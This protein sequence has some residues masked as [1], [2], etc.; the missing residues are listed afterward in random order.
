[1][2]DIL[3]RKICKEKSKAKRSKMLLNMIVSMYSRRYGSY[4]VYLEGDSPHQAVMIVCELKQFSHIS[5]HHNMYTFMQSCDVFHTQH[6]IF[7]A[8][9]DTCEDTM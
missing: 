4:R 7:F 1:M 6:A 9:L 8:I 2:Y 3:K 5:N